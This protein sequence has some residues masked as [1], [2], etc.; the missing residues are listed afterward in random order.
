MEKQLEAALNEQLN[1]EIESAHIYLAMAGYIATLGLEGFESWFMVQYEEEISHARKFIDYVNE[2]G[3]RVNIKGFIDPENEFKS[4][5]DALE[6][7]LNHEK[8]V[9]RRINN[10]MRIA[11]EVHDYAAISFL[12]WY[13]DEQVEEED[14]FTKLIDKVKLVKDAG[15]YHLDKEVGLR[16][17]VPIAK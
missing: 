1:F 4:L 11:Y 13:I 14:N 9:T 15:L 8:E 2:R 5:L 3:G 16:V 7:S 6:I 17:F 12:Q 10:L